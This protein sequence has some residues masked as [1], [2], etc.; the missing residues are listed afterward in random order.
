MSFQ[1]PCCSDIGPST[2][3]AFR[4]FLQNND[5]QRAKKHGCRSQGHAFDCK[6]YGCQHEKSRAEPRK[7]VSVAGGHDVTAARTSRSA[8]S[9]ISG[10]S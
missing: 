5:E 1:G 9:R 2:F 4:C 6:L 7:H 3:Q 8:A 10:K